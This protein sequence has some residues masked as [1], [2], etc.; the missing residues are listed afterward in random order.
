MPGRPPKKWMRNAVAAISFSGS[1]DDP[2]AVAAAQWQRMSRGQRRAIIESE[3]GT[4]PKKKKHPHH[5]AKKKKHAAKRSKKKRPHH[6]KKH[7]GTRCGHCGHTAKHGRA[8]CLHHDGT[9]FCSC[10]ARG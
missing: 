7:H 1:A 2:G 5:K 6:K 4:M 9:K 10:M 8:G 3:E